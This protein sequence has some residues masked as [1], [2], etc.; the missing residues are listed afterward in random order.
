MCIRDSL[1]ETKLDPIWLELEL[2]EGSIMKDPE[3]AIEKLNA[4]RKM[5]I[6]IAIDDFGT[7]YS[8]LSY[9]KRFPIDTLKIDKSFVNDVCTDPN[10][11][12]IVR[13]I[14]TLG[15]SLGLMVIAE[16]VETHGQLDYVNSI[17][18]DVVQGFLFS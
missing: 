7:G 5:G 15:H 11:A 17:G 16:G 3:Q 14:V 12:A 18:C 1:K 13:A 6:K 8:S 4:L 10:D 2:T 9:L